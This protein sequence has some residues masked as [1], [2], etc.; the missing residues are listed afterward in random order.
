M[1][2]A[3]GVAMSLCVYGYQFGQSNHTVYLLDAIHRADPSVLAGDWFTTQTFQYHAVF[4]WITRG[5]MR[6][7]IL[8]L[9]FGL[10][11]L[12]IVIGLHVA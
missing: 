8:E 4:G 5:L 11:Y 6:A 12:V 9:G 1:A 10:G 3:F 2:I 7:G